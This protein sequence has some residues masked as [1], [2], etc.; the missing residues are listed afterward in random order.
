MVWFYDPLVS[1]LPHPPDTVT[2]VGW[3]VQLVCSLD[4]WVPGWIL[5]KTWVEGRAGF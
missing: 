2:V 3:P 4:I 1:T 5:P